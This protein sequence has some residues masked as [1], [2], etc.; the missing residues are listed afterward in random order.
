M[1]M[2]ER[3]VETFYDNLTKG[4]FMGQRCKSCG[5]YRVFPVP[6]CSECQGTDLEL[7][8]LSKEG[9][10]LFFNIPKVVAA[11]F[12]QYMPCVS[13]CIQIKEGA[14]LW[15]IVEGIDVKNPD[16]EFA[17]LPIDVQIELKE[18]AGNVVPTAKVS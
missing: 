7:T 11:R 16:K 3:Y 12:E 8:E 2:K 6:V 18:I 1:E 10:L 17:R 5:T 4:K 9:R 13:G 15:C 14:V